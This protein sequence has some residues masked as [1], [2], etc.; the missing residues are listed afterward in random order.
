[1]V[2]Y[3]RLYEFHEPHP[4]GGDCVVRLTARQA[5][6][7][8]KKVHGDVVSDEE[9][10]NNFIA[11]HWAYPVIIDLEPLPDVIYWYSVR[12]L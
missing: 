10:L 3:N 8:S 2:D 7:Y 12:T 6:D 1:M 9:H 4:T 11:I 5:I